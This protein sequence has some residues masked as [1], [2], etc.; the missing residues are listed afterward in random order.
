MLHVQKICCVNSAGFVMNFWVDYLKED[1]STGSTDNTEN[2]P[3]GQE[4]TYDLSDK[5]IPEG[6]IIWP[7]VQAILGTNNEGNRKLVFA[8]NGQTATFRVTGT[9]LNFWV[10]MVG[11]P[12]YV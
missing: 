9:T 4:R 12:A 3:V 2:Y 10:E 1:G 5:N 6:S 11:S 7:H 8:R